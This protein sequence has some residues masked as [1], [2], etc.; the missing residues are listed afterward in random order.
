MAYH[1]RRKWSYLC[2]RVSELVL[3]GRHANNLI[4]VFVRLTQGCAK[5]GT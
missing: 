2:M 4:M 1:Q 3:I 5:H